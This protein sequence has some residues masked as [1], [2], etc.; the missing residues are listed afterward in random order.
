[1][2]RADQFEQMIAVETDECIIWP[3]A[4][5]NGYA[6]FHYMGRVVKGHVE[7]CTR[8]H[9]P[10]PEGM[11]H[12]CH[13]CGVPACINPRHLRWG[14]AADNA[15]DMKLHGTVQWGEQMYAA[16]LTNDDV[17]AIREMYATGHWFQRELAVMFGVKRE[18]IGKVVRRDRWRHVA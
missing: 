6:E 5:T 10:R 3:Y 11:S 16:K 18:A 4:L 14:T 8:R 12:T 13:S 2:K 15:A 7:S 17:R 1:M 9:G